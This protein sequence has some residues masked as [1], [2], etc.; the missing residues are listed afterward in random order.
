MHNPNCETIR[1]NILIVCEVKLPC[2]FNN[3]E[4][5]HIFQRYQ[6]YWYWP[7]KSRHRSVPT[8]SRKHAAKH[9]R[10]VGQV[11]VKHYQGEFIEFE[12]TSRTNSH[13]FTTLYFRLVGYDH[14]DCYREARLHFYSRGWA[15]LARSHSCKTRYSLIIRFSTVLFDQVVE[16][17]SW[18]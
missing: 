5:F 3:K 17:P 12:C 13:P 4:T 16:I 18:F 14:C 9:L 6:W 7:E 8:Q 15:N 10:G 1:L 11:Q 2:V